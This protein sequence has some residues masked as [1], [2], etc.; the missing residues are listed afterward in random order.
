M[1]S[2]LLYNLHNLLQLI[3]LKMETKTKNQSLQKGDE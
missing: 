3:K 2:V 1:Q